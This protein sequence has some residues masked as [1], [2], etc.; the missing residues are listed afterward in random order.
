MG[1]V[2]LSF[3]ALEERINASKVGTLLPLASTA[4]QINDVL[5]AEVAR[6]GEWPAAVRIGTGYSDILAD[7]YRLRS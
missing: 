7:Y 1:Q 4:T 6:A 2:A 5:L 3:G